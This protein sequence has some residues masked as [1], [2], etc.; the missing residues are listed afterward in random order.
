M[1]DRFE[2]MSN[3]VVSRID[4]MGKLLYIIGNR[5]DGIE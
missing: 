4:E 3:N 5:L 1:Q 2:D